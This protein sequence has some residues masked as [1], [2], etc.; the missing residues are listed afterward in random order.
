MPQKG[1]LLWFSLAALAASPLC[2]QAPTSPD[3]IKPPQTSTSTIKVETRVVLLDVVVTTH[4]GE[5]IPNL[6]QEDFQVAED[7]QPQAISAF[8]EHKRGTSVP[9]SLPALPPN[10]YTNIQP[11][12]SGDSVNILLIDL[13]N[14]QPWFQK[15]V[16]AQVIKYLNTVPPGTRLAI[17]TLNT[18]QLRLVRGFTT[19]F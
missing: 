7:G 10:S 17:F 3:A 8:E 14:T 5:A 18:E 9:V 13:L 12:K 2:A 15:G 19:D 6:S 4:K 16:C 1:Y 11:V